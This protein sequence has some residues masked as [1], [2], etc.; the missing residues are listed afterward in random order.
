M[1]SYNKLYLF[2]C[3]L[4]LFSCSQSLDFD[5]IEEYSAKPSFS[6]AL[7]SLTL[8]SSNFIV[9]S[10]IPVI[11]VIDKQSDFKLFDHSF[12]KQ[13]LVKLDFNFEIRNE[14]NRDFTMEISLLDENNLLVYKLQDLKINAKNLLFKQEEIISVAVNPNIVNFTKVDVKLVLDDATNP[15]TASDIGKLIFESSITVHLEKS[16]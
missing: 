13:N 2:L 4:V 15:I 7:A 6:V 9:S 8:D 3:L 14:F 12:I 5:Q 1:F 11:T 16:L 10:G